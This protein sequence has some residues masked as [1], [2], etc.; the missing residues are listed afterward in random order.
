MPGPIIA[1]LSPLQVHQA[2]AGDVGYYKV[3]ATPGSGFK[4]AALKK[5]DTKGAR[6]VQSTIGQ[7]TYMTSIE[8]VV[9]AVL[10][11]RWGMQCSAHTSM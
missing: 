11:N 6:I 8:R 7:P 10:P 9:K 5:G 1:A 3:V 4:L 2:C